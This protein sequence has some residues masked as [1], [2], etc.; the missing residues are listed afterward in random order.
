M[1]LDALN[2]GAI[3][4]DAPSDIR[5]LPGIAQARA[6]RADVNRVEENV[7]PGRD[8]T[9]L[10]GLG[11]I[12][13]THLHDRRAVL[14]AQ[15]SILAHTV[16]TGRE[17]GRSTSGGWRINPLGDCSRSIASVSVLD[18]RSTQP[19]SRS[20]PIGRREACL[21][22]TRSQWPRPSPPGPLPLVGGFIVR[23]NESWH[24]YEKS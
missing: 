14:I 22:S 11:C 1:R 21:G 6:D 19:I 2:E 15:H 12:S 23:S 8:R 24:L 3:R 13:G 5:I 7:A 4:I 17:P 18:R 20:G 16:M 10:T 9:R